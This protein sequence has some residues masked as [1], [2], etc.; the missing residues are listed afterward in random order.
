[1]TTSA[2]AECPAE[3][4]LRHLSGKWKPRLLRPAVEGPLRFNALLR[5]LSGSNRLVG[6]LRALEP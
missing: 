1:M 2:V 4:A 5:V 3:Q 6:I